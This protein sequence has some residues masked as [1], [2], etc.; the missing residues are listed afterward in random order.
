ME[1]LLLGLARATTR[2]PRRTLILLALVTV[3]AALL[4]PGFKINPDIASLL[5]ADHPAVELS[6]E[7]ETSSSR[8]MFLTLRGEGI[9]EYLPDVI[10]TLEDSEHLEAVDATLESLLGSRARQFGEAPLHF[11]SER[12][13]AD[14]EARLSGSDRLPAIRESAA[15]LAE[16][17]LAGSEIVKR[18]PLGLRWILSGNSELPEGFATDT[19]Y[20]LLDE[21]RLALL[22]V[23]GKLD[24]YEVEFS[25]ALVSD[26]EERVAALELP[27]F[28]GLGLIGG[29]AIARSD[30]ARIRSDLS[31]SLYFSIPLILLFLAI[32]TR[33]FLRAHIYL[34]PIALAVLWALGY[35]S[36]LLG[37][38]TPLAIS[39][40]AILIGLGVDF[41]IHYAGRLEE[42]ASSS[43]WSAAVERAHLGTGRAI[44][45]GGAT[46]IAAFLSF[47]FGSFPGLF[48]FGVLLAL[49]LLFSFVATLTLLPLIR[50]RPRPDRQAIGPVVR[51]AQRLTASVAARPLAGLVL[52]VAALGWGVTLVRGLTFDA[53]P[54]FLRPAAAN[55]AASDLTDSLGFSPLP[56]LVLTPATEP[57]DTLR[58]EV[59]ALTESDEIKFAEGAHTATASAE[60]LAAIAGFRERTAN[61]VEEALVDFEAVGFRV[62]SLR[63]ILAEQAALFD[64]DPVRDDSAYK[65]EWRG[66]EWWKDTLY[67]TGS[68]SDPARRKE[69][70]RALSAEFGAEFGEV[71]EVVNP[72]GLADELAPVLSSDLLLA[73]SICAVLVLALVLFWIGNLGAGL[74][75]LV[76]VIA[77]LGVAL[78]ALAF[79]NVPLHPGNFIAIPLILGLGVDDGIHMV[80]RAREK[81]DGSSGHNPLAI[82]GQ[83]IWRTSATT[84]LGFGSLITAQSPALA[85]LGGI[86]L[87]GVLVCF[88]TSVLVLP[89]WLTPRDDHDD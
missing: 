65:L 6:R 23:T 4:L 24:A 26:I 50:V 46:T 47:C 12:G 18:D 2:A 14:L 87:V 79:F 19:P 75:A 13:L 72:Y 42:E 31:S 58:A 34:A 76:P 20:L 43:E 74:L 89:P 55:R 78:G 37:P 86:A 69:L 70:D 27:D 33:S 7:L 29:Y 60:R 49:G 41:S 84:A 53:D 39:S 57:I 54:A 5:P 9:A 30:A 36:A 44:L 10:D 45:A 3:G 8:T 16:D 48:S 56:V 25:T 28:E 81:S 21:E 61:W 71:R 22:R 68:L 62:E 17:P 64:A 59:T 32:S 88:V 66:R 63:P 85:S 35:G 80:M 40:A 67:A 1:R 38:L 15:L 82:T 77:G 52:L 83:A 51:V 11:M 73:M